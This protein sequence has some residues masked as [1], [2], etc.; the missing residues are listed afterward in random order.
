MVLL[1]SGIASAGG[2][3]RYGA[4]VGT[5]SRH[6]FRELTRK[7]T[8]NSVIVRLWHTKSRLRP[9]FSQY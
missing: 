9:D 3:A 8:R 5:M 1:R 2:K 4:R 7:R 6:M